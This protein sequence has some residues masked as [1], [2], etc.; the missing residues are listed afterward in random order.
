LA[1][2]STATIQVTGTDVGGISVPA[3]AT[4]VFGNLTVTNTQGGGD[5]VLWPHGAAKPN[6]SNINYGPAQTVANSA[7]VGLSGDGKMDLF[8]HVSGTDVIFDV[9]G[10][11]S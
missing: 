10:F 4:G 3:G 2:A 11:V 1:G 6:A 5:L 8:V 9:A 7:N